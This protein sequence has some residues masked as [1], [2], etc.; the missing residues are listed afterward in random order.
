[1]VISPQ[2]N[3]LRKK[4]ESIKIPPIEGVPFFKNKW[5][6]GPSTLIGWPLPCLLFMVSIN[7]G[8]IIKTITNDVRIAQPALK[9]RYENKFIPGKSKLI[10]SIKNKIIKQSF[11]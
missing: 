2:N 1:M 11:L 7:F 6:F 3:V 5:L 4:L 8:P 9:D 10:F